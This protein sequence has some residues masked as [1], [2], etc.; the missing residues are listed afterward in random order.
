MW[1]LTAHVKTSWHY[2]SRV[3]RGSL[4]LR[5]ARTVDGPGAD[6]SPAVGESK[7]IL[8]PQVLFAGS[9]PEGRFERYWPSD[10]ELAARST[11]CHTLDIKRYVG[12][13]QHCSGLTRSA[14]AKETASG[15]G[16][17]PHLVGALLVVPVKRTCAGETIV[18]QHPSRQEIL[19]SIRIRKAGRKDLPLWRRVGRTGRL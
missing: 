19:P 3:T 15:I 18:D 9:G 10:G 14:R 12:V 1:A 6:C 5:D 7:D 13:L 4:A 8:H 17:Q 16:S 11:Y 2:Y